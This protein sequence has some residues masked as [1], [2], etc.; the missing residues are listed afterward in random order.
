MMK[1]NE[2]IRYI[3]Y[4]ILR[5]NDNLFEYLKKRVVKFELK[6][7]KITTANVEEVV[8]RCISLLQSDK[9][10]NYN[11]L[12]IEQL[13]QFY[14]L[15]ANQVTIWNE[16]GGDQMFRN[17]S[18]KFSEDDDEFQMHAELL[19]IEDKFRQLDSYSLKEEESDADPMDKEI[20]PQPS[21]RSKYDNGRARLKLDIM[22]LEVSE[23]SDEPEE[24]TLAVKKQR[25]EEGKLHFCF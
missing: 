7:K 5:D 11:V 24:E 12:V 6:V 19:N 23:D 15:Q 20:V 2:M 1:A 14:N 16:E 3:N 4:E 22:D 9:T 21:Y 8:N 13:R 25:T 17:D 18:A 10:I